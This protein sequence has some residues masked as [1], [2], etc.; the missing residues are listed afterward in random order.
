MTHNE[1]WHAVHYTGCTG[2]GNTHFHIVAAYSAVDMVAGKALILPTEDL[3]CYIDI[4]LAFA[5][6]IAAD[7]EFRKP[8]ADI[9]SAASAVQ[10]VE[11]SSA[12][13]AALQAALWAA[14]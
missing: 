13:A 4:V 2:A 8:A 10:T 6:D 12:S 9:A 7:K 5:A 1:D 14:A 3:D 11:Y